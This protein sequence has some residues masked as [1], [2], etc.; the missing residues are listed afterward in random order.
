[1]G[2]AAALFMFR[3]GDEG[4]WIDELFS[5]RDADQSLIDVYQSTQFRPLYY[6][7]LSGWMRLGSG[8]AWLRSLSVIFAV[9]AVFLI[10]RLGRRI[11]GET[12]GLIAAALLST[13][14][15]FVN[16]AQEVRM[17]ALSLCMGLAGTLFL[18]DAL[19]S[20]RT[21]QPKQ[22][23]IAGW[24]LFR[25]LAIYTVPLNLMLLIPDGLLI[26]LRFRQER[27]VLIKF[28][29]WLTLLLVLWL[30]AIATLLG[31]I[32]PSSDYAQERTQFAEAPGLKNLIYP[33]KFWMVWPFVTRHGWVTHNLYKFFTPVIAGLIGAGLLYKRKLPSLPWACAWLVL[34][35]IPIIVFSLVSARIWEPRYVL[36][37]SPYLFILI[38][39]GF[40]RIWRDWKGA[41][42]VL[43]V[44]YVLLVGGALG[45]Y[46]VVQNRG[47]YRDNIATVEAYEQPGDGLVWGYGWKIPLDYYYD[48][49]ADISWQPSRDLETPEAIQAWVDK[50]PTGHQ[51]LWLVIEKAKVA[52][53]LDPL[54][55]DSY[56]ITQRF[57]YGHK[58]SVLLLT[59]K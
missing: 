58:S 43:T 22:K 34:P 57:D 30:P 15:L 54:I 33:L 24:A 14:P 18:A 21:Q 25:L 4:F 39:A 37:V 16:H 12:E 44:V 6:L 28:A 50:F 5:I 19:L 8:D 35:L 51:R 56:S 3:L 17:Y 40:A 55:A 32:Q 47:D 27:R 29:G 42:I 48:G 9:I 2:T 20:D 46:Y 38:A 52:N 53:Q 31:D 1:M 10:Y 59:A 41:A 11:A 7:L 49:S 13:S 26:L 23:T 36:F 45:D